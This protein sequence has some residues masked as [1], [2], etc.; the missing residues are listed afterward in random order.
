MGAAFCWEIVEGDTS[1]VL[2]FSRGGFFSR[3]FFSRRDRGVAMITVFLG[4]G[5]V[6]VSERGLGKSRRL[7]ANI[8]KLAVS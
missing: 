7:F 4:F 2:G 5:D 8:C 6:G 1:C 3:S